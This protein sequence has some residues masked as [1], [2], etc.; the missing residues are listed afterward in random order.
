MKK[1][2]FI[3]TVAFVASFLASCDYAPVIAKV[4]I[5]MVKVAPEGRKAFYIGKKEVTQK[6]WR[7]VMGTNPSFNESGDNYPIENVS[8]DEVM[9]FISKLN[10]TTGLNYRLPSVAEWESAAYGANRQFY[11]F[12]GVDKETEL[13]TIAW[14]QSNSRDIRGEYQTH[15][16]G[17]KKPN[18]IGIYDMSGNVS[19]MTS[20]LTADKKYVK[21]KGGSCTS[22][23]ATLKI[24]VTD[25][26]SFP[27]FGGVRGTRCGF[28]L[29]RD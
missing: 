23:P 20:E 27:A 1:L 13:D 18:I 26:T 5:E 28:R 6:Q 21:V 7:A 25:S 14:Y 9:E 19:E 17:L 15:E 16:V 4:D 3:A 22:T 12:A 11:I 10:A 8:Y 29:A 2:T 24:E